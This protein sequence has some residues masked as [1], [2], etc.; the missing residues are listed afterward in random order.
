MKTRFLILLVCILFFTSIINAQNKITVAQDPNTSLSNLTNPTKI[1]VSLLPDGNGNH[2]IGNSANTW[3]NL[4]LDSNIYLGGTKFISRPVN[5]SIA[6]GF[7]ALKKIGKGNANVAVGANALSL[8]NSGYNN[9]AI[10][11]DALKNNTSG[12]NLIAVGDSALFN[13]KT[14]SDDYYYNTA[15]GDK[16]LFSN[17]TGYFNTAVGYQSLYSNDNSYCDAF[18]FEAL[19]SNTTGGANAAFGG[20]SLHTNTTG[21]GNAGFGESTLY[22]NTTGSWNSAI[23]FE[24][25]ASNTTGNG[26]TAIGTSALQYNTTGY[27][28]TAVGSFVADNN[29]IGYDNVAIA[30]GALD[31]N[32]SGSFNV[33]IGVYSLLKN[34]TASGNTAT[35]YDAGDN[36][37]TGSYNTF[38]GYN[39][40]SGLTGAGNNMMALGNAATVTSNNHVVIGNSSVTSIGGYVGWS[41]ISDG[42]V[43]K[44]I[45]QNVPG[46]SFINKLQPI[47]YNLDLDAA[48][49]IIARPQIKT[50]QGKTIQPTTEELESR[51]AKEQF[52]Y[53]GFVAQDVEKVAKDLN[54]DFSGVDKPGNANTLYGLRYSD[55]VVPLV[56]A[57]QELSKINDAKDSIINDL[58]QK[59]NTQQKQIDELKA[60][61]VSNNQ[62]AIRNNQSAN[63]SSSTGGG[64]EEAF[65]NPFSNSTTINYS[66]PVKFSSAK[67]IVTDKNGNTLKQMSLANNKGSVNVNAATLSSGAYQ[68]SLYVDGRLIETKQMVLAK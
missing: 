33:A 34:T 2:N 46:L 9:I 62:Q 66:L 19:Y 37:I 39:A 14:N 5:G 42:R 20:Y 48:D 58:Q 41:N 32:T 53:T 24:T 67:I 26:N 64:W 4:F 63:N 15:V 23:G 45:K 21:E 3:R 28:N 7:N 60:M 8:N 13:Q 47:T 49:N 59:Y 40:N 27:D 6:I 65:P 38:L 16:A 55:F 1:N 22:S 36:I 54:Y 30:S 57:V 18:G 25:L 29:T 61:I 52:V 35:G 44:N 17:I 50:K 11:K 31:N 51:K 56:K 12:H 68:Y 10:G 43:K